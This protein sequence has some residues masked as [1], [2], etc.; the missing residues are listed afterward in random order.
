MSASLKFGIAVTL[1]GNENVP[2]FLTYRC[3]QLRGTPSEFGAS[4][5]GTKSFT[6]VYPKPHKTSAN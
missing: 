2:I 1:T 6:G 4:Q 5:I 3:L